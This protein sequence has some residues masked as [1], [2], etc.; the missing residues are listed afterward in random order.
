MIDFLYVF[1]L[2]PG[3]K[4]SRGFCGRRTNDHRA[5]AVVVD[6]ARTVVVVFITLANKSHSVIH[7]SIV[8]ACLIIVTSRGSF[9]S[10]RRNSSAAF[11]STSSTSK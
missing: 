9:G 8:F 3:T 4:G 7:L 10:R 6:L 2:I 5:A 11:R 1:Q